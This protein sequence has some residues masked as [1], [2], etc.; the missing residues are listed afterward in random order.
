MTRWWCS[1]LALVL[2]GAACSSSGSTGNSGGASATST[3]T[4]GAGGE[5][6]KAIIGEA[7]YAMAKNLGI[8]PD[9]STGGTD[10]G[11]TYIAFTGAGAVVPKIEDHPAAVTLGQQLAS[12]LVTA[13]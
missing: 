4:S 2:A 12:T 11:V 9:P 7:S 5:G 10:S 6:P 1:S 8:D 13:N 3:S